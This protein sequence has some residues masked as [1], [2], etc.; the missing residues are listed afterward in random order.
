[1][2][3]LV[4]LLSCA[5]LLAGCKSIGPAA[6]REAHPSFNQ[7]ISQTIDEQLLLNL[8]RMKYRDNTFF[9]E[10]GNITDSR[11]LKGSV[12]TEK[13]ELRVNA[14]NS[15][16][17]MFNPQFEIAT[18]QTPTVVY[19]PLQGQNFI[20]RMF[21]PV[22]LPVVLTMA[23]SG[24]NVARV[25]S[26]FVERIND[27]E[28]AP[29]A[30]GP[31]PE[32]APNYEKF[33]RFSKILAQLV[34]Q[35]QLVLGIN[36]AEQ[37]RLVMEVF[38]REDNG[39]ILTEFKQLLGISSAANT[40]SFDENFLSIAD[41]SLRIRLRSVQSAMFYLSNGI[42]VPLSHVN[43]GLVTTTHYV[44]GTPFDWNQVLGGLFRV[45][46]CK[47]RPIGAFIA[48]PYRGYWF[49]IADG[50]LTSKSTFMLLSNVFS[51]QAGDMKTI[52]PTLTLPV[53]R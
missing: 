31:T 10:I 33:A 50:D 2:K 35:D 51:L 39:E 38:H 21:S 9:L 7:A 25:F 36:P 32:D 44:D 5:A 34:K 27:L 52:A 20:K 24:W 3:K 41:S 18:S 6:I 45:R 16:T 47:D 46:C 13:S 15:H 30:S 48:I 22:P 4:C 12:G 49:Y 11:T 19:T 29:T 43:G 53:N 17:A 28:N 37:K 8:V 14:H 1:M 23:Q 26:L 42:E 40:F